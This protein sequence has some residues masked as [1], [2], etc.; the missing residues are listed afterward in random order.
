M[1]AHIR[2]LDPLADRA[3]VV[4]LFRRAADYVRL[5]RGEEPTGELADE[6]FADVLPGRSAGDMVKLGLLDD[7]PGASAR[8]AGLADMGFGFP[9]PDAAYL[10]LL[11]LDA[12]AR[13]AGKGAGFLRR[14]E[15]LAR[16][17]GAARLFLA[18]LQENPRGRAFWNREGFAVALDGLPVRLGRR[19]H[20][21]TRMV[22]ALC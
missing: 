1:T 18:V 14:V 21:A 2:P 20:L 9:E 19:E 15:A 5:E 3:A 11:L 16:E 7:A 6:F 10:G 12:G 22:K 13:G 8:L 17:R 4:D